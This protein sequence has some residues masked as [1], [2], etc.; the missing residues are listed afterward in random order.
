MR[1]RYWRWASFRNGCWRCA[2]PCSRAA[3]RSV[4]AIDDC[5]GKKVSFF[6][7]IGLIC[8]P[9]LVRGGAVWQLVGLITRRSQ[10]QILPPL[11]IPRDADENPPMGAD[12]SFRARS[13]SVIALLSLLLCAGTSVKAADPTGARALIPVMILDGESNPY[14]DWQAATPMLRQMLEETGLFRI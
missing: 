11:P 4:V 9:L 5:R 6:G 12:S 3:E 14:H 13:F 1:W 10:V 7:F 2:W 8:A